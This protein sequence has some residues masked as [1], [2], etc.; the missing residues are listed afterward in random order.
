MDLP[1]LNRDAPVKV[2][3]DGKREVGNYKYK[4]VFKVYYISDKK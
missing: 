3:D 4:H 2:Q 1:E